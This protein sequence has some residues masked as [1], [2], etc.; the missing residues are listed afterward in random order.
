MRVPEGYPAFRLTH[1]FLERH[2][3]AER[4]ISLL[5]DKHPYEFDNSR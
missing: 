2:Y 1:L 3:D 5:G 4:R